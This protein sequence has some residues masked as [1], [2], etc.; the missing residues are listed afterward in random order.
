MTVDADKIA[1]LFLCDRQALK[2]HVM[3]GE[4]P[5]GGSLQVNFGGKEE[6]TESFASKLFVGKIVGKII[7][8]KTSLVVGAESFLGSSQVW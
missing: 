5:S 4:N 6:L 2:R 8:M 3:G 1:F 7:S